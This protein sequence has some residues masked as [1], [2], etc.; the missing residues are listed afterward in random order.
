[1]NQ[2]E[3]VVPQELVF[4]EKKAMGLPPYWY[5]DH[6]IPL[7]EGKVLPIEPLQALDQDWL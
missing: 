4:K 2:V 1:M 3:G 5:H 6:H 7:L